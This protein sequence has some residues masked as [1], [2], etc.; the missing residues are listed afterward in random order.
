[1][2]QQAPRLSGQPPL[3]EQRSLTQ[4]LPCSKCGYNLCGL[5][6]QGV[7]PECG[8]SIGRSAP[9]G[10]LRFSDPQWLSQLASGMNLIVVG[11]GASV[12]AMVANLLAACLL[13]GFWAYAF[14]LTMVGMHAPSRAD[15]ENQL[16]FPFVG[17]TEIV[18]VIDLG[19]G[20]GMV[21]CFVIGHWELTTPD[22]GR[23]NMLLCA[24]TRYAYPLSFG[25]VLIG[26][27]V[28]IRFLYPLPGAA[29]VVVYLVAI[30]ILVFLIATFATFVY[31]RQLALRIPD[32]K[33]ARETS[34]F[35]WGL[36]V[37]YLV[38]ALL[39]VN[40]VTELGLVGYAIV[41][42]FIAYG[43][44]ALVQFRKLLV[45]YLRRLREAAQQ[46]RA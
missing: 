28:F 39:Y 37:Y 15:L 32:R 43:E 31:L 21:L 9:P 4:D 33:Q 23:R 5:S 18:G 10:M 20:L 30:A 35:M 2:D 16:G 26:G 42:G 17:A 40:G 41:L 29:K 19:V 1:M 6:L 7:C 36:A 45:W 46:A 44:W 12:V 24:L 8:L 14:F 38:F 11:I 34:I 3:D 22:P 27:F 25:I 13:G